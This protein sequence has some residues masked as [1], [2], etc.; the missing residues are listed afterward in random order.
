MVEEIQYCRR[1]NLTTNT[2]EML[3]KY[4]GHA[5]RSRGFEGVHLLQGHSN[6]LCYKRSGELFIHGYHHFWLDST[7]DVREILRTA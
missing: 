4:R 7:K 6:F 2:P 3:E 1:H 5:I